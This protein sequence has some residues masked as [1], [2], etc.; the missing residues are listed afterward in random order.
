MNQPL[1]TAKDFEL[2]FGDICRIPRVHPWLL[3]SVNFPSFVLTASG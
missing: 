1:P 2:L 3:G